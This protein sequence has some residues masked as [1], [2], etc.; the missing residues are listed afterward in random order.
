[1]KS[2]DRIGPSAL[3][4]SATPQAISCSAAHCSVS[5]QISFEKVFIDAARQEVDDPHADLGR[6]SLGLHRHGELEAANV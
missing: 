3:D 2:E 1:M 5:V 4:G 6:S